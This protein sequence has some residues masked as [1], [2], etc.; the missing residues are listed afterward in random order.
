MDKHKAFKT[1][2]NKQAPIKSFKDLNGKL[3]DIKMNTAPMGTPQDP[4]NHPTN[5]LADRGGVPLGQSG[6]QMMSPMDASIP[7]GGNTGEM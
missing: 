1:S 3:R 2:K 5:N 4:S 6:S 7:N